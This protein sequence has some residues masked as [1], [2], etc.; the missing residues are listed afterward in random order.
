RAH[1]EILLN[2]QLR[3]DLP[4]FGNVRDPERSDLEGWKR[5]DVCAEE[6]NRPTTRTQEPRDCAQRRAL[7]GAI[8]TEQSDCFTLSDRQI[9]FTDRLH[10]SVGRTNAG[11]REQRL[12]HA[13]IRSPSTRESLP[14]W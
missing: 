4:P 12:R 13:S 5:R 8:C 11:K 14:D 3:K 6:C 10:G 7:T 2:R 9:D 1:L